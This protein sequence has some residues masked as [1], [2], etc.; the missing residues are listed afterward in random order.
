MYDQ[1]TCALRIASQL[2]IVLPEQS[3]EA[4]ISISL[5]VSNIRVSSASSMYTFSLALRNPPGYQEI[6]IIVTHI[7]NPHFR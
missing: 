1:L 3:K 5:L 2:L 6:C 4:Y 7:E